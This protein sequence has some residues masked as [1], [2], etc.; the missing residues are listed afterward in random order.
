M[1]KFTYLCLVLL[2]N[3]CASL[4]TLRD[5]TNEKKES[6]IGVSWNNSTGDLKTQQIILNSSAPEGIL[7]DI[8]NSLKRGYVRE[9]NTTYRDNYEVYV[10]D[11]VSIPLGIGEDSYNILFS[12]LGASYELELREGK[13]FFRGIYQGSYEIMLYSAGSFSRKITIQNKLKY[14]FP[15]LPA[16]SISI[17][18][19]SLSLKLFGKAI[20]CT[21]T[22]SDNALFCWFI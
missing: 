11:Y 8:S 19:I 18:D 14:E 10:G 20:L 12:P 4:N 22:L 17:K 13:L 21:A 2:L 15:S 6:N 5:N 9:Y 3:S 7:S 16:K 1:K